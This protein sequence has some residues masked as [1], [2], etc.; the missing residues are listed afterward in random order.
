MMVMM[1]LMMPQSQTASILKRRESVIRIAQLFSRPK[2]EKEDWEEEVVLEMTLA[3]ERTRR[4]NIH[5]VHN[6]GGRAALGR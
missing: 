6:P 5:Y 2:M 4:R 3:V 1:M